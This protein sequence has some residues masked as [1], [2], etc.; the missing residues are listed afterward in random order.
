MKKKVIEGYCHVG[1][2]T[3]VSIYPELRN[4]IKIGKDLFTSEMSKFQDKKVK[5]TIEEIE[6]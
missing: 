6:E 3:G 2:L 4:N 1:A 5:I